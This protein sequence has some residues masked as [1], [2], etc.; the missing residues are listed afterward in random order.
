LQDFVVESEKNKVYP[1]EK[2]DTEDKEEHKLL[3]H[4]MQLDIVKKA[5]TQQ[6]G[7]NEI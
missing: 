3:E 1:H 2:E 6:S 5:K 4:L 7:A